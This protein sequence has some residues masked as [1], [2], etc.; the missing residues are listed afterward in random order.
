MNFCPS[1]SNI[2][3]GKI[4]CILIADYHLKENSLDSMKRKLEPC[5]NLSSSNKNI[6]II[7][8]GDN[9]DSIRHMQKNKNLSDKDVIK[10]TYTFWENYAKTIAT[11]PKTENFTEFGNHEE[12]AFFIGIDPLEIINNNCNNFTFLGINQGAI[13]VGNDKIGI[14]HKHPS[15]QGNYNAK[16]A[17]NNICK[18]AKNIIK[19][20]TT[21][22]TI[23]MNK[24]ADINPVLVFSSL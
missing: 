11:C 21:K 6:P 12:E 14:Y 9:Q 3:D 5:F 1:L 7:N 16:E 20:N 15:L 18:E 13:K 8:F 23:I 17:Y 24:T 19:D 10:Y 22:N 4:E 2:Y